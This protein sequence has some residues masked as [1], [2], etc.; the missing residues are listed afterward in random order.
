MAMRSHVCAFTLYGLATLALT[1]PGV[2]CRA[3]AAAPARE[4]DEGASRDAAR[5]WTLFL[6]GHGPDDAVPWEFFCTG[7]NKSGTWTTIPVPS[8]WEQHG[9]GAYNYGLDKTKSDERGRYRLTFSVPPHW[10]GRRVRLV[11]EGVMT[12]TAV[13]LNGRDAGPLHQGGFYR[14][15]YDVT[16]LLQPS[17]ENLLE[18][19]VSKV[20]ADLTVED[21][22]RIA[23]YW[24]FGGIYR[25]VTLE[26]LPME[27]IDLTAIDA[28]ADG[29]FTADVHLAGVKT[30]DRVVGQIAAGDGTPVGPPF[31]AVLAGESRAKATLSARADAPRLWTA[32]TPNLYTVTFSL[33]R[34]DTP[35]HTIVERFGFRT[36]E[37]RPGKGLF[38]NGQR[39]LLKGVNRHSF[40]PDT[41]RA[42][43]RANCY[44]DAKTIQAMNMN[45]VR[46]SHY[47]PDKAFLEAC[48][49]L[50]L[51]VLDELAGWQRVPYNTE[52]GRKLVREMVVR[53][54][55]H[56]CILFWDNGNEGGWN[57][58]LDGDFVKY[59]RSN[60]PVLHPWATF[61][62]VNTKHYPSY[63]E[64]QEL[65]AGTTVCMPTEFLHGLYDGGHGAGLHDYWSLIRVSP[66]AG[67]G[68]LWVFADEGVA[69]MDRNGWIDVARTFAPDGILGPRHE[70]EGSFYTIREIFSPVQVEETRLPDGFRGALTV[71]NEYHFTPLDR[72]RFEWEVVR[73][74]DPAAGTV[75][76]SVLHRGKVPAPAAA[77][78]EKGALQLTLPADWAQGDALRLTAFGH[79]D[80]ALWTWT[81]DQRRRS[82]YR[83]RLAG[84]PAPGPVRAAEAGGEIHLGAGDLLARFDRKNARLLGIR[85]G[86]RT[87]DLGGG[88]F[89]VAFG[90][91][92]PNP[93][94]DGH[95]ET[96][97]FRGGDRA[98]VE[99]LKA[100]GLD[101]MRW[102]MHPDG[103]LQLD[104]RYAL[105]GRYDYFGVSFAYPETRVRGMTWLG[106][107]PY[108]VWKNRMRGASLGVHRT[109]YN[110]NVP[111]ESWHYPEFKGYFAGLRWLRL[112]TDQGPIAV[113]TDTEG[114]FFRTWT[115][116][117]DTQNTSPPFPDGDLSFLH[118]IPPIGTKFR[119]P[120]SNERKGMGPESRPNEAKGTYEGVLYFR[121]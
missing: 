15:K 79:R 32:E 31:E 72:C 108:R 75:E 82:D 86:E 24:V 25:P 93:P 36:F 105:E 7:G 65:L 30:A 113:A 28:R 63:A 121:F 35:V 85:N 33:R 110:D 53:D 23:D 96:V 12:D 38:L 109:A 44:D 37:V 5:T 4:S 78:G 101:A 120:Y 69:R 41:G 77:P 3:E 18:V 87:I 88:P 19:E 51:Y 17:R 73:F 40:R 68:F 117:R 34:G 103:L 57:V 111:G 81:W 89:L 48:D 84:T 64:L 70:R 45:A 20:S 27:F 26:S 11:F 61:G 21:A 54:V 107:G 8:N 2:P 67:G 58:E 55:N 92:R 6:S 50:G 98:V 83:A 46:M 62:N 43:T 97:T 114:L 116:K 1:T 112:D 104:Y 119:H 52:V 95:A 66:V 94:T 14:F 16:E 39:I 60:R 22:E 118:A 100:N 9:F 90:P 71:R 74:P 102:T 99:A 13:K 29:T 106:Q 47:P 59:D 115:P 42:L 76:S 10:A 56:P 80:E 91:K 49:E